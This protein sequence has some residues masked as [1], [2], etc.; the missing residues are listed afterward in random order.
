MP[1][2][3]SRVSVLIVT[4]AHERYVA[5]AIRSALNQ[6]VPALEVIVVDD[7]SPDQTVAT[8]RAIDDPRVRVIEREHGGI[9]ALAET[10][11]AGLAECRG[12]LVALLEG[13]DRWPADKLGWQVP[14]FQDPEVVVSHGLYA[15]IGPSGEALHPGVQPPLA[16]P[17]G[18]YDAL[19]YLLQASYVMPVTAVVRRDTLAVA[20][21]FHQIA[22]TSHCDYATFL[23]LARFGYFHFHGVALGEWR[24]HGSAGTYRLIEHTGAGVAMRM[25][26]EARAATGRPELPTPGAIRR[27]WGDAEARRVWNNARILLLDRR[28]QEARALLGA[29]LLRPASASMR[30]RL[31]LATLAALLH[32]DI[33]WLAR[34]VGG[35]AIPTADR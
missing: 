4:Y 18:K 21:G 22:G 34:L 28:Y 7:G 32:R 14:P 31:A 2:G 35:T 29:A 1:G 27:A 24:R 19:P 20:G 15:V 11:N 12:D 26:L 17:E 9:E 13:D 30:L 33:E 25:A 8:A 6:T 16:I 23:P 10:Y 3:G 5:D